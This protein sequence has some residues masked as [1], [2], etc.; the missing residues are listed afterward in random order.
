MTSLGDPEK[1]VN[2]ECVEDRQGDDRSNSEEDLTDHDVE[3]EY[4][5]VWDVFS[6]QSSVCRASPSC[7]DVEWKYFF[8]YF[9]LNSLYLCSITFIFPFKVFFLVVKHDLQDK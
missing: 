2:D 4:E 1:L 6:L 8:K 7:N 3:L 9:F 5:A